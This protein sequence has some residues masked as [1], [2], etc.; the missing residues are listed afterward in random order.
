MNEGEVYYYLGCVLFE[1]LFWIKAFRIF[2]VVRDTNQYQ[3]VLSS[4]KQ[5]YADLL[6][7]AA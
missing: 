1:I 2:Q 3:A 6:F 7:I 4:T 5:Y